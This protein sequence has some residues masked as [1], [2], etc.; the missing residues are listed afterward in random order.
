M[1]TDCAWAPAAAAINAAARIR[2]RI[3]SSFTEY[4]SHDV[5]LG[6]A[7]ADTAYATSN[8]APN[9]PPSPREMTY[10]LALMWLR[11]WL[12]P[13]GACAVADAAAVQG[14]RCGVAA[15][16]GGVRRG[17]RTPVWLSLHGPDLLHVLGSRSMAASGNGR[18]RDRAHAARAGHHAEG[19]DRFQ[20][21]HA[22]GR[23]RDFSRGR[24]G[25]H[26]SAP[27]AGGG[28]GARGRAAHDLRLRAGV[29]EGPWPRLRSARHEQRRT[30]HDRRRGSRTAS[31]G[32]ASCRWSWR[33]SAPT[34]RRC[35]SGPSTAT[36]A[37]CSSRWWAS[38][39]AGSGWRPAWR[40]CATLRAR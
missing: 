32:T 33:S 3:A 40:R 21:H 11:D 30:G 17:Q 22:P 18:R 28:Q 24:L 36:P 12:T 6:F 34:S 7:D 25:D 1:N 15:V 35:A 38:R 13:D 16:G 8:A 10:D 29:R 19:G 27:A 23:S 5:P 37:C 14:G 31:A 2:V 39:D 9:K 26:E 4:T 20:A